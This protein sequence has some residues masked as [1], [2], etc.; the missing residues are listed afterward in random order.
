MKVI[1]HEGHGRY[2]AIVDH[3]EIEKLM[4][5][6]YVSNGVKKL[7]VGEVL[8][9]GT[10]Y[11]FRDDI[12]KVCVGMMETIQKFESAKETLTAFS[13]MVSN[14]PNKEET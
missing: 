13:L 5:K 10:G 12:K 8:D 14:L 2:I 1:G 7:E 4:D 3:S 9:L 6:W 11:K